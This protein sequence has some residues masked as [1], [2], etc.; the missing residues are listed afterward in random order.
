ML[1]KLKVSLHYVLLLMVAFPTRYVTCRDGESPLPGTSAWPFSTRFEKK[2]KL[3]ARLSNVCGAEPRVLYRRAGA[4]H[5][6][7]EGRDLV[8][9]LSS[10]RNSRA[11]QLAHARTHA[12]GHGRGNGVIYVIVHPCSFSPR[13]LSSAWKS[14]L[15]YQLA[16]SSERSFGVREKKPKK[17]RQPAANAPREQYAVRLRWLAKNSGLTTPPRVLRTRARVSE[18]VLGPREDARIS[19]ARVRD[20]PVSASHVAHAKNVRRACARLC[21]CTGYPFRS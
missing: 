12:N 5:V 17:N 20:A 1:T 15:G 14:E 11:N 13:S 21:A 4:L 8:T 7:L 16:R 18:C 2:K 10:E 19:G 6:H 3:F 9:E